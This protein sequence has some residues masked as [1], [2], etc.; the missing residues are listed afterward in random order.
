M[1]FIHRDANFQARMRLLLANPGRSEFLVLTRPSTLEKDT[2]ITA[3]LSRRF[4]QIHTIM[5]GCYVAA[6]KGKWSRG[7]FHAVQSLQD[8]TL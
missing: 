1:D 5:K 7:A 6:K 8:W 3:M 4:N 2:T